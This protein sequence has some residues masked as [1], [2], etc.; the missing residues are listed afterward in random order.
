MAQM[1]N[2]PPI[3][4]LIFAN[5]GCVREQVS[6]MLPGKCTCQDGDY[7]GRCGWHAPSRTSMNALT[8]VLHTSARRWPIAVWVELTPGECRR[9]FIWP[10]QALL[11]LRVN[12]TAPFPKYLCFTLKSQPHQPLLATAS[13]SVVCFTGKK[14]IATFGACHGPMPLRQPA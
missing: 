9:G 7:T 8:S 12:S 10:E 5:W 2:S 1:H 3:A 4:C 13:C 14:F 6:K 11:P